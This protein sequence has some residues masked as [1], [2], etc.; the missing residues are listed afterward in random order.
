MK[1]EGKHL[2]NS[3][4]DVDYT[5]KKPKVKFGYPQKDVKK[6]A[7]NHGGQKYGFYII[8]ILIFFIPF[9][10]FGYADVSP[11]P[12]TY[13]SEC[14]D[15]SLDELNYT[16][17]V[18]YKGDLNISYNESVQRV[19]GF[20]I[21]CDNKTH[22]L[23]FNSEGYFS[24]S[25]QNYELEPKIIG[26]NTMLFWA[27]YLY[28]SL[29]LSLFLNSWLINSWLIKQRWYQKWLPIANANGVLIKKKRK[30]YRKFFS[31]DVLDSV[32]IIPKFKNIELDYKT[33]GDFNKYLTKIKIRE[34]REGKINI[35]TGKIKK[36]KMDDLIWYAIFYFKNKPKKGY[37]EVIYQ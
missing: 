7:R 27:L 24:G 1:A 29:F 19:Y 17:S 9:I 31:K 5:G 36:E 21:T 12:A 26:M 35:K 10:I 8:F 37:L 28:L 16:R 2:V 22:I 3:R 4:V 13:P 30:K 20:N 6:T 23:N 25:A 18:V 32:V 34:Y 14:G 15:L 11:E 33:T